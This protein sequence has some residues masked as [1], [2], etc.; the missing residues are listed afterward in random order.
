MT[1]RAPSATPTPPRQR[2]L[3]L[4]FWRGVSVLMVLLQHVVYYRFPVFRTFLELPQDHAAPLS[5]MLFIGDRLLVAAA[6]HSGEWGVK[7]FFVISGYI[8][9]KLMLEEESRDGT[10]SAKHFYVRRIFRILPAYFTYLAFLWVAEVAGWASGR[11]GQLPYAAALL[12]NTS[13]VH[14]GW[15]IAHTWTL[16]IE[17]QFYVL[18]PAV[19]LLSGQRYRVPVVIG[20]I[21]VLAACSSTGVLVTDQWMDNALSFVCIMT[22]A[23]YALSARF[24]GVVQRRGVPLTLAGLGA[25]LLISRVPGRSSL[26][27]LL[28]KESTPFV[29]LVC[30][31]T[32]YD[33]AWLRRTR[34]FISIAKF[35]LISYSLYIWQQLFTN[36]AGSYRA[37]S[38]LLYAPLMLVCATASYVY[39]EKPAIR[40]GKSLLRRAP[41][42]RGAAV[43]EPVT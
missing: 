8:I 12:C 41:R 31:I 37:G 5:R 9:T 17:E 21:A 23:L 28:F 10:M 2:D 20:L 1:D 6:Y 25:V 32:T 26:A 11:V 3:V 16:A 24:R 22:G 34:P 42:T 14:C 33:F 29:I 13:V 30:I 39:I 43:T 40:F 38:P 27:H 15:N 4:D 35:G 7:F 19:Y 36:T 18:W